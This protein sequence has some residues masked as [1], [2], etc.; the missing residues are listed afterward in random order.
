M[1]GAAEFGDQVGD[2]DH[3]EDKEKDFER[4]GVAVN[5]PDFQRD[6]GNGDEDREIFRPTFSECQANAFDQ[7]D[8]G[9]DECADAQFF[10]ALI[11][12]IGQP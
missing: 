9:I 4:S 8:C 1:P 10:E 3:V 7:G 11:V 2:Y 6:E 12:N 5:F